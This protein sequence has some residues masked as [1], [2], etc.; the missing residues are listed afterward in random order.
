M[1]AALES[2]TFAELLLWT[3][4]GFTGVTLV[5]V[6]LGFGLERALPARRIWALPLDPGQLRHEL[7]GNL[8]FIAIAVLTFTAVIASGAVRFGPES[9]WRGTLTFA[10]L[11]LGFQVFYYGLHRAMHRRS[12]VRFHRWHHASRVTTPLSGQS[13]SWVEALGWM[14]G[15]AGLPLMFSL[16]VPISAIGW[17]AYVAYN[18]FGNIVGHANVELEPRGSAIRW[19]SLLSNA[20]VYHALHHARWSGHYGFAAAL[21]DR[22]FRTE[23]PD[24]LELHQ[25]VATGKPLTDLRQRGT[26]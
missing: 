11:A 26:S 22:L 13:M 7:L 15:Y 3:A 4:L 19:K 6:G 12:L 25:R 2:A 17:I 1:A 21:M 18:V 24:W 9:L 20:L 14:L 8:V 23:W 16:L 10:A 5:S